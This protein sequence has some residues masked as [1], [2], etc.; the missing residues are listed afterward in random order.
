LSIF[1]LE[2]RSNQPLNYNGISITF[3]GEIYNFISL[4]NDLEIKGYKFFTNSDTEVICA[5][6]L[7]FGEN[8][9]D[10]FIGMFSFVIY[11]KEKNILFGARDRMGQK[12]FYYYHNKEHF[13]FASNFK[14]T[15]L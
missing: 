8:C 9:V 11:D 6:Y 5:M 3:N 4:R 15:C 7:E 14:T 1:D 10:Y 13:E 12:P 2:K